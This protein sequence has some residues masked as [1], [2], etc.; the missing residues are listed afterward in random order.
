MVIILGLFFGDQGPL[1]QPLSEEIRLLIS[2][3]RSKQLLL[4]SYGTVLKRSYIF[5]NILYRYRS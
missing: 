3:S 2:S 5:K 4:G 1:G